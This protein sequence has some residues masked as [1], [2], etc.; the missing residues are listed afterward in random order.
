M[1]NIYIAGKFESRERLRHERARIYREGLGVV[2]SSWLDVKTEVETPAY[3]Y[4]E[5]CRDL[6]EVR[7]SDLLI[8]DTQEETRR[9]GRET[10]LGIA[11]GAGIEAWIVGT[12]RSVFH[13]LIPHFNSWDEVLEA[14]WKAKA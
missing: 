3:Y 1:K 10:E 2:I 9:G 11:L 4:N 5:A 14:L 7:M 13:Y 6:K 12:Q 8:L